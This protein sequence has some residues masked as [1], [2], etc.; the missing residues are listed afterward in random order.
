MP[1]GAQISWSSSNPSRVAVSE[2]NEDLCIG[3]VTRPGAGG[4]D[5]YVT[6]TATITFGSET[7]EKSFV[8][9]VKAAEDWNTVYEHG[10]DDFAEGDLPNY[11]GEAVWPT[12]AY[13]SYRVAYDPSG[14]NNKA[15]LLYRAA[16]APHIANESWYFYRHKNSALYDGELTF[17]GRMYLDENLKDIVS[18]IDIVA[19]NGS[20]ICMGFYP[21]GKI[22]CQYTDGG[23]FTAYTNEPVL[24]KGQWM[25]FSVKI[26]SST[27]TYHIYLDGECVTENGKM[28]VNNA[29]VNLPWGIHYNYFQEFRQDQR[30]F[31]AGAYITLEKTPVRSR[32]CLF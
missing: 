31:R 19:K 11:P 7:A 27:K 15:A 10:Y 9:T 2:Y 16:N 13:L 32:F 3:F 5:E 30:R 29:I 1:G 4:D 21:D 18:G 8:M 17:S 14:A 22:G 26:D 23:V 6:I 20:Q 25:N 28:T 24:K 12:E